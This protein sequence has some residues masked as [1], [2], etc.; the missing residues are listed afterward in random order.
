MNI[1]SRDELK[2]LLEKQSGTGG[3]V[4]LFMPT[5]KSGS[6]IRQNP[7]RLKNLLHKA[8][9]HLEA[10]VRR[11]VEARRFLAPIQNLVNDELF[12]QHPSDG[13]AIFLSQDIFRYYFLPLN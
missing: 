7:V 11:L 13:L 6:E 12:W 8:E 5:Y 2:I 10:V 9:E 3:S 4:S 1:F